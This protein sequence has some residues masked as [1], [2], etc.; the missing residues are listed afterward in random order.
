MNL[1]PRP[2]HALISAATAADVAIVASL[3]SLALPVAPVASLLAAGVSA[4]WSLHMH[5]KAADAKRE[6]AEE[7]KIRLFKLRVDQVPVDPEKVYIGEGWEVQLSDYQRYLLTIGRE[8][9]RSGQPDVRTAALGYRKMQSVLGDSSALSRHQAVFGATGSGK[10]RFVEAQIVQAAMSDQKPCVIYIDPKGDKGMTNL[11][12]SLGI[13][14]NRPFHAML[15]GDPE[16]SATWNPFASVGRP[17]ELLTLVGQLIPAS[18][19]QPFWHSWPTNAAGSVA[20]VQTVVGRFLAAVSRTDSRREVPP[21]LAAWYLNQPRTV[22]GILSFLAPCDPVVL[23]P[24]SQRH[25]AYPLTSAGWTPGLERLY[26]LT[27]D[28]PEMLMAEVARAINPVAWTAECDRVADAAGITPIYDPREVQRFNQMLAQ[29]AAAAKSAGAE[30]CPS[31]V[32]SREVI[33]QPLP[34][35]ADFDE[36]QDGAAELVALY[37]AITDE[38]VVKAGKLLI[39]LR[40]LTPKIEA[41]MRMDAAERQKYCSSLMAAVGSFAGKFRLTDAA[42]PE[43]NLRDAITNGHIL[44]MAM[45]SLRSKQSADAFGKAIIA[46]LASIA[47][48]VLNGGGIA[49]PIYLYIDEVS[50]FASD[51]LAIIL[52]QAR[53]S[54]IRV[55]LLGQSRAALD[56]VLG[57][58][59]A[60]DFL[61]NC[62]TVVQM[63]CS[64][65]EE[66]KNFSESTP[67]G[68]VRKIT[69]NSSAS[70]SL[71]DA[72]NR[73]VSMF[74]A[75]VGVTFAPEEAHVVSPTMVKRLPTGQAWMHVA[76]KTAAPTLYLVQAPEIVLPPEMA[77]DFFADYGVKAT[78]F[79]APKP[80]EIVP[81]MPPT[82]RAA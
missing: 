75:N 29:A 19:D 46:N 13:L 25:P 50:Q 17:E 26:Q 22:Q 8:D 60:T 74:S 36:E 65:E 81:P 41:L 43:I 31:Y 53:A 77:R 82:R 55:T 68:E 23:P 24:D 12:Y 10:T 61:G 70:P 14:V 51:A 5:A 67:K 44:Y 69:F 79:D 9:A 80:G 20:M 33:Q 56:N 78:I 4:V 39:D 3:A 45:D 15:L 37:S 2:V 57:K 34:W 32:D 48:E 1:L 40:D 66:A 42:E 72:G 27:A 38:Q 30:P 73:N 54:G 28:A 59:L 64:T 58:E 11:L 16:H 7:E 52:Q 71:G 21:H 47:G 62:G 35:E 49:R 18:E 76:N 63:R 6:L